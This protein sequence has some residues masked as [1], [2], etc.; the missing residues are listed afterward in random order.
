MASP[1]VLT[2]TQRYYATRSHTRRSGLVLSVPRIKRQLRKARLATRIS[3]CAPIYLAGAI[4]YLIAEVL[5]LAGNRVR[6]FNHKRITPRDIHMAVKTDAELG[7]LF[8]K[9]TLPNVGVLGGV[10]PA[11]LPKRVLVAAQ[12]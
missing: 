10:H 7:V 11:L 12:Q 8:G 1:A 9:V 2:P 4:E 3:S 5:E 6:D